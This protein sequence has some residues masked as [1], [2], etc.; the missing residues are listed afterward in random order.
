[1]LLSQRSPLRKVARP[2]RVDRPQ[3]LGKGQQRERDRSLLRRRRSTAFDPPPT[4]ALPTS[5]SAM[6][7]ERSR[8]R[9]PPTGALGQ[10]AVEGADP[11]QGCIK[12]FTQEH[13]GCRRS[14]NREGLMGPVLVRYLLSQPD[15]RPGR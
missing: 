14:V 15:G 13:Q 2:S 11:L 5:V 7:R 1:M 3:P 6:Q 4:F 12:Q 8:S 10:E 9:P